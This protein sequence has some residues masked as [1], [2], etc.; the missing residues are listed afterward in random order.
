MALGEDLENILHG[1]EPDSE[2]PDLPRLVETSLGRHLTLEGV[3]HTVDPDH[4]PEPVIGAALRL[5]DLEQAQRGAQ[6]RGV[7]GEEFDARDPAGDE[8]EIHTLAPV[9]FHGRQRGAGAQFHR[10]QGSS[11]MRWR[12]S[13]EPISR[14]KVITA[15]L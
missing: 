5:L 7:S 10:A 1:V 6:Q 9:E 4:A 11:T 8:L 15:L 12:S 13:V 2:A 3:L 14:S